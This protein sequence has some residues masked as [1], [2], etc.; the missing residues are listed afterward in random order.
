MPQNQNQPKAVELDLPQVHRIGGDVNAMLESTVAERFK[1]IILVPTQ[2]KDVNKGKVILTHKPDAKDPNVLVS[3][4]NNDF[5]RLLRYMQACVDAWS[6]GAGLSGDGSC[7]YVAD[8]ADA[9]LKAFPNIKA[10]DLYL[11]PNG[12]SGA[13]K[14]RIPFS[15]LIAQVKARATT[16]KNSVDQFGIAQGKE[17]TRKSED[18]PKVSV[19]L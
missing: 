17:R 3:T 15:D 13:S 8:N 18:A 14:Y 12:R 1:S 5:G 6:S 4:W 2:E 7:K 19:I 11:V 16:I 9:V 10:Y